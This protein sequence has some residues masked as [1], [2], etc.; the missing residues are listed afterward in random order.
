MIFIQSRMYMAMHG[1]DLI[2][3][4]GA[5]KSIDIFEE[6][7]KKPK[8]L[9]HFNFWRADLLEKGFFFFGHRGCGN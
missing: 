3:K 1:C 2:L 9:V 8:I 6:P 5:Q 4:V 7:N